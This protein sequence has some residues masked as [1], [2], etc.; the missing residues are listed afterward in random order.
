MQHFVLDTSLGMA[1]E[2]A[3]IKGK[4]Y[5][6]TILTDRLVRFEYNKN[7]H[8]EDRPTQLVQNRKFDVPAVSIKEDDTYLEV[9]TRY[10]IVTY[11]KEKNFVGNKL[12]PGGNL[13]VTLL[14]TDTEKTWYFNHP[15]VRNYGSSNISSEEFDI[16]NKPSKGLYSSDG[17]VSIDDSKSFVIESNGTIVPRVEETVDTYLF[18]YRRDFGLCL[19]DYFDLTGK[20]PLLPRYALGN[21]WS[22]NYSYKE[23]DL[24]NLFAKFS[25]HQIPISVLLM[26]KDWHIRNVDEH[27]NLITGFT[28]SKDFVV[29]SNDFVKRMHALGVRVGLNVNPIQ[30]IMPHE[31][32]YEKAATYMEQAENKPIPFNA[33]SMKWYNMYFNMFIHPLEDIGIDFFWNDYYNKKDLKSL[34]LLNH[35]HFLDAGKNDAKRSMLLSR[36]S[37]VAGH[38]YGALYSGHIKVNWDMLKVLPSYNSSS[39]NIGLSWWSHDIGGFHTGVE[40]GELYLRYVQLGTFSPIFRIHVDKG[41]YYKREP[42]RWDVQTFAIIKDYMQLRHRLIPYL[43]TEAYRYHTIGTPLI[44]P[45]Y[46]KLPTIYDEPIYKNEYYLGSELVVSPLTDR[47][48][49]VMNRVVHKFYL[50]AGTWYDFKTGKKFPGDH[51][52]VSFFRDEDYPVFAKSGSIIPLSNDMTNNTNSPVD[53]EIHIFPG[54]SNTYKLYEDDGVTNLY[55]QGYYL[56]T[57]IDYNYQASNY[58]VIIRA[59]EGKSGIVPKHR[60][61]KLRFRNTKQTEEII[62]Y[63]N[64]RLVQTESYVDENDFVVEVKN[65][66]TIGQLAVNCKGKAI[67]I[68]AVRLINE[69]IDAIIS[70][71]PIETKLKEVIAG[72]LFSDLP[73]KKKRIEIKKL[74]RFKIEN[75]FIKM[76][77]RLL[78]YIE[79][80]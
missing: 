44:Q 56:L 12:I 2:K 50:P 70:D 1:Q 49:P 35:Y 11:T 42:W 39:S 69:D 26:D 77:I 65:V 72:I 18:A 7:G 51:S 74:K 48:D 80:I 68:D 40:D 78:E 21:W 71:L 37:I 45:L 79:Q 61:Y 29:S 23:E 33:Y 5:R 22:K 19:K 15:E 66:P 34:W 47:K 38:R 67:E 20:P 4:F 10:F 25:R 63:V 36:N 41:K 14:N 52:Y 57:S 13:R 59:L 60:N 64:D 32:A 73:I 46:Y 76:F 75:K 9:T 54:R 3:I 6:I 58:T 30:G 16:K 31:Q 62:A 43:Y 55:K 17:F 53:M 8:F 27:K 28:F 24:L